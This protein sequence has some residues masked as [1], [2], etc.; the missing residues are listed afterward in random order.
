MDV[1]KLQGLYTLRSLYASLSYF[2]FVESHWRR[3]QY[4]SE[5][6]K[7]LKRAGSVGFSEL[8][9][10]VY[11]VHLEYSKKY[12]EVPIHEISVEDGEL[13]QDSYANSILPEVWKPHLVAL[14]S[15]G[16]GNCFYR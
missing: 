11:A 6:L 16:D 3:Q 1:Q 7:R 8:E 5:A 14:Q 15:F 13:K 2:L 9:E 4:F 12:P 10:S